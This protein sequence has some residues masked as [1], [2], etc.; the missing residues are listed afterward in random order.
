MY[1]SCA[2]KQTAGFQ[3]TAQKQDWQL[4]EQNYE[5][6]FWDFWYAFSRM[7][8]FAQKKEQQS[9][10]SWVESC[11]KILEICRKQYGSTHK[12]LTNF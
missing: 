10:G 7:L 11:P 5:Q 1:V 3:T 12:Q 4:A 8:Y 2:H 9:Y 6:G